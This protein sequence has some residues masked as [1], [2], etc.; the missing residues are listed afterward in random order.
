MNYNI[1]TYSIATDLI[2]FAVDIHDALKYV[3]S[4]KLFRTFRIGAVQLLQQ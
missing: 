4:L 3:Y 1:A 2:F